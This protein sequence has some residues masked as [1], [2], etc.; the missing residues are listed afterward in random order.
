MSNQRKEHIRY[1][2]D[3]NSL[4]MQDKM[5][6]PLDWAAMSLRPKVPAPL[7]PRAGMSMCPK[8]HAPE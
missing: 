5:L 7:F 8:V 3:S 4:G 2:I 1:Y 6:T